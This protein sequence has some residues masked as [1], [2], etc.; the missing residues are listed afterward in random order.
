MGAHVSEVVSKGAQSL[1]ALKTLKGHGL[2]HTA[3]HTVCMAILVSRLTYALPA[4]YGFATEADLHHNA[5]CA[6]QGPEMG[7]GGR[8]HSPSQPCPACSPGGLF[9]LQVSHLLQFPCPPPIP[10]PSCQPL[11]PSSSPPP[12]SSSAFILLSSFSQLPLQAAIQGHLLTAAMPHLSHQTR[13]MV[14]LLSPGSALWL[15]PFYLYILSL[16]I[17][18]CLICE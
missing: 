4:W 8:G 17:S 14:P 18:V 10:P 11:P 1:F 2:S 7:P 9:T 15:F 12:Q 5:V 16:S 3:L 6:Q 13:S